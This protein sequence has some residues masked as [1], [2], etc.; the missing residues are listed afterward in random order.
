MRYISGDGAEEDSKHSFQP[1]NSNF[2]LLAAPE[3]R[4]KRERRAKQVELAI[5]GIDSWVNEFLQPKG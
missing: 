1:M 5:A 3:I 2:G 4:N